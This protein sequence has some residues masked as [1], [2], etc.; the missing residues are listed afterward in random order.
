MG[1]LDLIDGTCLGLVNR[2]FYEIHRRR[3]CIVPLH[4]RRDRPNDQE[5]AWRSMENVD[6]HACLESEYK[7]SADNRCIN[8]GSDTVLEV[9]GQFWCRHCGTSRCELHRHL[10]GWIPREM[11]YCPISGKYQKRLRDKHRILCHRGSPKR[12]NQCGRHHVKSV[13]I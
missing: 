3:Q 13:Q 5:W 1:F 6:D 11:E 2:Y 4:A 12:P 7:T 10:R 9:K 8:V